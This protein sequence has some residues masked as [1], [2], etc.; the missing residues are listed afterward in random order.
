MKQCSECFRNARALSAGGVN[1]LQIDLRALVEV[2]VAHVQFW[3]VALHATR[4]KFQAIFFS[5]PSTILYAFQQ[6]FVDADSTIFFRVHT[7][8]ARRRSRG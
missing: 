8:F 3:P 2:K 4:I 6:K 1:V 5:L 7:H